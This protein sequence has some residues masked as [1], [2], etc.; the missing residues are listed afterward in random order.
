MTFVANINNIH[1]H[2]DVRMQRT[3]QDLYVNSSRHQ[4][5]FVTSARV[6]HLSTFPSHLGSSSSVANDVRG[7]GTMTSYRGT[8]PRS[9]HNNYTSA[10][11]FPL[12]C[13]DKAMTI[14]FVR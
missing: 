1:A 13:I 3:E 2:V 14:Y 11:Y 4:P 7:D 8:V 9:I 10:I 6:N 12:A 5:V